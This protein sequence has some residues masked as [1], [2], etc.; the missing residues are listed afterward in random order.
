MSG[1]YFLGI[2]KS[3]I[4]KIP[5]FKYLFDWRDRRQY[6]AVLADLSAKHQVKEVSEGEMVLQM[7]VN[8][9][10]LGLEFRKFPASDL[11][12]LNQVFEHACYH[13]IVKKMREHYN[14]SEKLRII[15]AGANVGYSCVYFLS[16]FP[17]SSVVAIEPE[18]GNAKQLEKNM[19]RNQFDPARL[20]RG[21]LWHRKAFLEVVRDFRDNRESAFT[22]QEVQ[23]SAGIPGYSFGE[24]LAAQGWESADL[25]KIDIEGGERF[26]FD[27]EA[28]ADA[29]LKKTKYLAIEIHDEFNIRETIYAHLKRNHFTYFE[30]DDLTLAVSQNQ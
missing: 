15:D 8:G 27:T 10:S 1:L 19:A 29:I 18:E 21:A 13:P 17:S 2:K 11:S 24:L 28:N 6:R 25:V 4:K 5:P 3:T 20:V 16:Y 30:F 7:Q 22:V 12:V 23:G 14:G 9:R 26:L